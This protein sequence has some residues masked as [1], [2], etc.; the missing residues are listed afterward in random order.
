MKYS[1][2]ISGLQDYLHSKVMGMLTST[3]YRDNPDVY[4]L[5]SEREHIEEVEAKEYA[6]HK[7]KYPDSFIS[8]KEQEFMTMHQEDNMEDSNYSATCRI[9]G[10]PRGH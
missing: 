3:Q 10:D 7:N 2:T 5:L 8:A 1:G 6:E 4:G 9:C